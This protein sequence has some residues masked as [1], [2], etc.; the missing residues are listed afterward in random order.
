MYNASQV[1]CK[2]HIFFILMNTSQYKRVFPFINNIKMKH[3][4]IYED[5]PMM[6][7]SDNSIFKVEQRNAPLLLPGGKCHD[8][9]KYSMHNILLML[10]KSVC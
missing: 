1:S 8:M 3:N 6:K 4:L 5:F 7:C 9:T 10:H 2:S